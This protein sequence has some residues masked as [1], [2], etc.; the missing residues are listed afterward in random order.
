MPKQKKQKNKKKFDE[1]DVKKGSSSVSEF[2]KRPVPTE[3]EVEEFDEAI[4]EELKEDEI[5]ESLSEIYQDDKGDMVNVQKLAIKKK[6]G[7]WHYLFN[8][9][10]LVLIGGGIAYGFYNLYISRNS[11]ENSIK[12]FIEADR[13]V[14]SGEEFYYTVTYNNTGHFALNNVQIDLDFSDGFVFLDSSPQ[15]QIKNSSWFIEKLLPGESGKIKIKGKIIGEANSEHLTLG[16]M[17]YVPENFSSEFKKEASHTIIVSDIGFDVHITNKNYAFVGEEN[18]IIIDFES[19]EK[20]YLSSFLLAVNEVENISFAGEIIEDEDNEKDSAISFQKINDNVWQISFLGE[21]N[22]TST[23]MISKKISGKIKIK[24]VVEEKISDSQDIIIK[25]QQKNNNK[26]YTFYEKII[27]TEIIKGDFNLTLKIN[28]KSDLNNANFS[29]NLEY[30]ILY[31]NKGEANM[32]DVVI[33]AVLN[34]DFLDW[35]TLNLDTPGEEEGNSIIWTKKEIPALAEIEPGE[36]GEINFSINILPFRESDIGKK[37]TIESY[38]QYSVGE[39]DENGENNDNKSNTI[40]IN[41]NSDLSLSEEVRYFNSDNIPVG[42]GPLPPKVDE[43]TFFKV[44]WT[45]TNNLHELQNTEVKVKLPDYVSWNNKSRTSV[46]TIEY[47]PS[48]HI[49]FWKIGRLPISVYRVDAEF[50]ISITPTEED[51]G[52][53]MVLMPGSTISAFDS[54]TQVNISKTTSA[55]TTKLEDDNIAN[56]NNDGRVE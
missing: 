28:N 56:A 41:I 11:G 55:K 33:E 8:F 42:S 47:N 45:V 17:S 35:T 30:S 15:P 12:F 49:V 25:L 18:E 14:V 54:E 2:I 4:E 13:T 3:E 39:S 53:I 5:E 16:T 40:I 48:E 29:D 31:E 22:S 44:Y 19:Q 7:F 50:S 27:P 51:R 37:P 26:D 46:G 20:N 32:E 34:S 36:S 38:A 24:Y 23:E 21:D 10:F 6:K 1:I 9:L 52:R 43:T